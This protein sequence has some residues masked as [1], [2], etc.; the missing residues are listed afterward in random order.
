MKFAAGPGQ[1]DSVDPKTEPISKKLAMYDAKKLLFT[2]KD[3]IVTA[4][5]EIYALLVAKPGI[6][7]I[8]PTKGDPENPNEK[9]I[10]LAQEFL[11]RSSF[12]ELVPL[13]IRSYQILGKAA[14]EIVMKSNEPWRLDWI[15]PTSVDYERTAGGN[16]K[17]DRKT[18]RPV[19][20]VQKQDYRETTK[21][22]PDEIVFLV[23]NP[24]GGYEPVSPLEPIVKVIERKQNI[25]HGMAQYIYRKGFPM[26]LVKC[27]TEE[28]LATDEDKADITS[29]LQDLESGSDSLIYPHIFDV[30]MSNQGDLKDIQSAND[31]FIHQVCAETHIPKPFLLGIGDSSNRATSYTQQDFLYDVIGARQR[32]LARAIE[33]RCFR[34]LMKFHGLSD[35]PQIRFKEISEEDL[36]LIVDRIR[37][38]LGTGFEQPVI[39]VDEGREMIGMDAMDAEQVAASTPKSPDK[40]ALKAMFKQAVVRRAQL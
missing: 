27:G 36:N 25:E 29:A 28:H 17:F 23:N 5:V 1:V 30:T 10:E 7:V 9:A 40:N 31:Y 26:L 12:D 20:F 15:Y 35:I 16:I 33:N 11:R 18:K 34:G 38:L 19:G 39:T 37:K 2:Y 32:L 8:C 13:I 6:E 14:M 4:A 3:P 22:T 24:L 21:Y